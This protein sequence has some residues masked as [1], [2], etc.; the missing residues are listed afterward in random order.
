MTWVGG[1]QIYYLLHSTIPNIQE[2]RKG[3]YNGCVICWGPCASPQLTAGQA[4][5]G[6]PGHTELAHQPRRMTSQ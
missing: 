5:G 1:G 4:A 3:Q 6:A 2:E